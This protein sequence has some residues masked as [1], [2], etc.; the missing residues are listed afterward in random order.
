VVG[1]ARPSKI[2][3][4]YVWMNGEPVGQWVNA[5]NEV[6]EFAYADEWIV[7][8][9]ARPI[10][11]SMP[12]GP[13]GTIYRG[14]VVERFFENLLPDSKG[15]RQRIRQRFKAKSVR[16]FDLLAEIGRDCMGAIQLTSDNRTAPD[17]RKIDGIPIDEN[18]IVRLLINTVG[19]AALGRIEEDE[20]FRI[21]L[22]GAQEKTAL[23][24][25]DG[26]WMRPRGTTPTTHILKLPLGEGTQGIDLSTSVENEWLCAQIL[27]A[28]GI[29]TAN[30]WMERFGE[31]QV[32]VVE[33]FDRR[34][35]PDRSWIVR[36][37][38]EDLCQATGTDR[39]HKYEADG[40]PGIE[41][42]MD[43]LLGSVQPEQDRLDFFRTQILF[44]MLCAIDGHAKNFSVFLEAGGRYKLTPRY[45]VLSAFPVLG[46]SSGQL[47]AHKVKMA[48]A[49]QSDKNRH[50]V[51]NSIFLRHWQ[52]MAKHCGISAQFDSLIDRLIGQTSQVITQV[53]SALPR[54]FPASVA[55]PV[56]KGLDESVKKLML[57]RP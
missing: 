49:V 31:Q 8:P 19:G 3:T 36:L 42:I 37:P 13:P 51:W 16:A 55:E 22:A 24:R 23:L 48:M 10:S 20:D 11:L 2:R 43:V 47:S 46:K 44:W 7:S 30:C 25:V 39:E 38:Q 18:G 9:I 12:V 28:Y 40:G 52:H 21:S 35:A 57:Y 50:Y 6:Q 17:V 29:D 5:P 33:R 26:Q 41:T 32:L 1:V 34:M 15:I 4:L 14:P 53:K 27:G 45:D 56:L 54:N